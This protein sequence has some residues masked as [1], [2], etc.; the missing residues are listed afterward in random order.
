MF[1]KK[2]SVAP[3][4]IEKVEE[5]KVVKKIP[6]LVPKAKVE[7]EPEVAQEEVIE[8]EDEEIEDEEPIEEIDVWSVQSISTASE[9]TIYNAKDKQHLSLFQAVAEL[10]NRTEE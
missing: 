3:K 9:P 5:E 2:K 8:E 7:E 10:L 6:K 1:G 4:M